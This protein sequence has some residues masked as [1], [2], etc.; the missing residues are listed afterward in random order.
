[1]KRTAAALAVLMLLVLA[2]WGGTPEKRSQPSPHD[3]CADLNELK[4][5][6]HCTHGGDVGELT[7]VPAV[8][9]SGTTSLCSS[10]SHRI[11]VIY[12]NPNDRE[13]SF[14]GDRRTK[15]RVR[16]EIRA[17]DALFFASTGYHFN[18]ACTAAGKL[19]VRVVELGG[20]VDVIYSF[21][22]WVS[23]ANTFLNLKRS[24]RIYLLFFDDGSNPFKS[25]GSAFPY[26]GQA[27]VDYD[28]RP[29]S[30]NANNSGPAYSLVDAFFN[31]DLETISWNNDWPE[32][33]VV[34]E[35]GHNL[36]AVIPGAP[37]AKGDWHC[38]VGNDFMCTG[39]Q[40]SVVCPALEFDCGR[41]SYFDPAH[42]GWLGTHWNTADSV[43]ITPAT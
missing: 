40:T 21:N 22:D 14:G 6:D 7:S 29:G 4:A 1:M 5:T 31:S 35:L 28:I 30:D 36:G 37:E 27:T 13:R 24:D 9:F 26:N 19:K 10:A 8:P 2:L 18:W 34:H 38:L 39:H 33:T 41:N 32:T 42:R 20:V 23:D 17:A 25:I 11:E 43:W 12:G 16:N 15:R 3:E